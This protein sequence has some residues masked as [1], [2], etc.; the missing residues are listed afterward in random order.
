MSKYKYL[1]QYIND[2]PEKDDEIN[3]RIG[4]GWNSYRKHSIIIR[5]K[6]LPI[7]LKRKVLDTCILPAMT[8]GSETWSLTKPQENK[9]MT[10]QGK[11]ERIMLGITL[12]DKV[13]NEEIRQ[14]L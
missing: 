7:S 14:E 6:K 9:L 4:S 8:Y 11:M 1:G 12:R 10:T 2:E 3:A 13:R 5:D